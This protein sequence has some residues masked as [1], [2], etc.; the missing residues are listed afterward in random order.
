MNIKK[1]YQIYIQL[2]A[3]FLCALIS[4]FWGLSAQAQIDL[5]IQGVEKPIKNNIELH[6]S[7]WESLPST[8][9]SSIE[10]K[11]GKNIQSA[12]RAM[13][14][15]D[16]KIIYGLEGK[17]LRLVIESG[18]AV[19]WARADIQLIHDESVMDVRLQTIVDSNPFIN[20][21]RIDHSLYENYKKNLIN[22]ASEFGYLDA[23]FTQSILRINQKTHQAMVTLI[24]DMGQRYKL[25]QVN[26]LETNIQESLLDRL[27]ELEAEQWYSANTV[28][29]IYNRLLNTGYFSGVTVDVKK[30]I[31]NVA[32]LTI[33]LTDAPKHKIST[34]MGFGTDDKGPRLKFKWQRP[35][36]NKRGDSFSTQLK[37][38]Q[39]EQNISAQ[40]RMPWSHPLNEYL[41]YDLG[42]QQ[43]KTEDINTQLA[44]IGAS[45]HRVVKN[46][47]QYSFH[48]DV[49]NE[50]S[51]TDNHKKDS[52][53]YVIPGV[54][55]SRRKFSG[56]ATDPSKGYKFWAN[57]NTSRE[58]LGSDTD[59]HRFDIG[60]NVITTAFKKHS[61]LG[62]VE[63][64]Y[65]DTE[66]LLKVPPSQRFFAGGDQTVRGYQ[67]ES[68]A[69]VDSDGNLTGG[70]YSTIASIEYRYQFLKNWKAA[71][72]YDAAQV[73]RDDP[74]ELPE[75]ATKANNW[76]LMLEDS[77]TFS[78]GAGIGLRWK[79]PIGLVAFDVA[80]PINQ[81][82]ND[83][84][85]HFYLGTP[86]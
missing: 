55:L 9:L 64:G 71:I 47:W 58:Q 78:S 67:Y 3:I 18:E 14:Y 7:K 10:E 63:L 29:L 20:G 15:Y 49:E 68:I 13:G 74:N 37:L 53:T 39:V 6:L 45:Y 59:F 54:Q 27:T 85:V 12:L 2:R 5:D 8:N 17:T 40:F 77:K 46:G 36:I 16:A 72:F 56:E 1:S 25:G 80:V 33:G 62:R 70:Q 4:L 21:E 83:I 60:A 41:S 48:F 84:R 75:D 69:P 26:Y 66:N 65:I 35:R 28:G 32:H 86:L 52:F 44:T 57:F 43:K 24:V 19:K 76:L 34:G 82:G 42:W 30:E 50:T 11:L 51:E 38:S 23:K 73:Y 81:T 31:P 79:T 61:V 22:L